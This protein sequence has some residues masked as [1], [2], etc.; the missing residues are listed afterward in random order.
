MESEVLPGLPVS[1]AD[2]WNCPAPRR[3]QLPLHSPQGA[4]SLSLAQSDGVRVL[5]G[6]PLTLLEGKPNLCLYNQM[7][8]RCGFYFS[9]RVSSE[10]KKNHSPGS[11]IPGF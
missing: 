7:T 3:V 9:S 5:P 10:C 4:L 11:E 1:R 8:G 2:A 6:Y